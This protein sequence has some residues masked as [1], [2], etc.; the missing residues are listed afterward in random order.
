MAHDFT[1]TVLSEKQHPLYV[2]KMENWLHHPGEPPVKMHSA[3]NH[4]GDYIGD[5]A[6]AQQLCDNY[7]IAPETID[8]EHSVCSIGYSAKD[9]KWYGWSHRAICGFGIGDKIFE[10]NFGDDD[11]PFVEHGRV[12][13]SS[14]GEAKLAAKRFAEYIG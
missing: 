13:I 6:T 9:N 7:G 2:E 10:E 8:P 3:Y 4:N 12:T 5:I 1:I 11:T 14:M